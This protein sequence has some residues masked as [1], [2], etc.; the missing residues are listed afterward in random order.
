ME[1]KKWTHPGSGEVRVYINGLSRQGLA[2][3][4]A[5]KASEKQ[6]DPALDMY[7]LRVQGEI[8]CTMDELLESF[9]SA[10]RRQGFSV[11]TFSEVVGAAN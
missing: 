7:D 10:A 8:N 4:F 3:I 6:F 2:K 1:L 9:E 11:S 5:V